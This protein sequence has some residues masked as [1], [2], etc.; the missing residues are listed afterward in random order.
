[1]T[2]W[3]NWVDL[4]ILIGLIRGCYVGF[5]RGLVAE[6]LYLVGLVSVTAL[7]CNF[8]RPLSDQI[9]PWWLHDPD[10]LR[11][12]CFALL[13]GAGILLVYRGLRILAARVLREGI[14]PWIIGAGGVVVGGVKSL[15]WLG[16]FLM[17]ILS[18]GITY[19]KESVNERSL[20]APRV[21]PIAESAIRRV[22]DHF[23]GHDR[24]PSLVP[25]MVVHLPKIPGL[26]S[27]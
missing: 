19:L 20:L 5:A 18:L 23:P 22:A 10:A 24:R 3:P 14:H 15:W 13:F 25:D 1:M 16:V 9:A 26:D 7:A 2:K 21:L 27:Q 6:L 4:V 8:Y 12:A 17:V 11:F